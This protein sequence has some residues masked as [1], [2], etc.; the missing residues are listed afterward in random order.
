MLFIRNLHL[1]KM[2]FVA[3][4]IL[5]Y[6]LHDNFDWKC[7]LNL[8]GHERIN[9]CVISFSYFVL[10]CFFNCPASFLCVLL[11]SAFEL[12]EDFIRFMRFMFF[13]SIKSSTIVV[14]RIKCEEM[15]LT[16]VNL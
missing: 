14:G 4:L 12:N 10:N 11:L 15:K 16:I 7:F 1:W 5:F 3:F 2:E 13:L 9:L 6:K 8:F